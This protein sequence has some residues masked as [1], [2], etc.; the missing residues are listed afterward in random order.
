MLRAVPYDRKLNH[1]KKVKM[2]LAEVVVSVGA[3]LPLHV[4]SNG[5]Q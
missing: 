4:S 5:D 1:K 2:N 3:V